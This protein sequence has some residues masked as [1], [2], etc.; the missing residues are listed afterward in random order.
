ML[1]W[2]KIKQN[3]LPMEHTIDNLSFQKVFPY[4]RH[5]VFSGFEK[6]ENCMNTQ[7]LLLA[8][9]GWYFWFPKRYTR[10]CSKPTSTCAWGGGRGFPREISGITHAPWRVE[11][12]DTQAFPSP[13]PA[14]CFLWLQRARGEGPTGAMSTDMTILAQLEDFLQ[15]LAER[16]DRNKMPVGLLRD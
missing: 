6:R 15:K 14:C 2:I 8:V 10:S 1:F 11:S 3:C 7:F 4:T 16:L 13:S 5:I 12:E 9:A